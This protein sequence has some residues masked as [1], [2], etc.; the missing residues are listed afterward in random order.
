MNQPLKLQQVPRNVQLI[1]VNTYHQC[2]HQK[3]ARVELFENVIV[4]NRVQYVKYSEAEYKIN[5]EGMQAWPKIDQ[6]KIVTDQSKQSP[7][8]FVKALA[9]ATERVHGEVRLC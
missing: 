3:H 4:E 2:L 9:I 5:S 7:I 6:K 8:V 1:Y